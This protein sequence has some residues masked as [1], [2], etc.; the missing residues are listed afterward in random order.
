M[1]NELN[2]S[3]RFIEK[4]K[5]P[6]FN[7]VTRSILISNDGYILLLVKGGVKNPGA[8]EFPGGKI[9]KNILAL[10]ANKKHKELISETKREINEETHFEISDIKLLPITAH[11]NIACKYRIGD[12]ENNYYEY[13]YTLNNKIIRT[14]VYLYATVLDKNKEEIINSIKVD[15]TKNAQ[16]TSED[17][18]LGFKFLSIDEY[19]NLFAKTT[20]QESQQNF[21][22]NNSKINPRDLSQFYKINKP[23]FATIY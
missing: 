14:G 9:D 4:E 10:E 13:E 12:N 15:Q 19:N 16:G 22:A 2:E 11:K 17:K 3:N 21:I 1:T 18:H 6:D 20:R 8:L 5:L 7:I 23:N